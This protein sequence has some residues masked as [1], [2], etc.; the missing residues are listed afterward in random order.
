MLNKGNVCVGE[1]VGDC[2]FGGMSTVIAIRC[3]ISLQLQFIGGGIATLGKWYCDTS[4]DRT[5]SGK[6]SQKNKL[7]GNFRETATS[8]TPLPFLSLVGEGY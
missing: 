6:G 2:S 3:D 5:P 1:S 4:Q 8:N 7:V